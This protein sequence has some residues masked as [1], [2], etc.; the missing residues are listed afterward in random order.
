MSISKWSLFQL[1]F[2]LMA[3][4]GY[5]QQ[6]DQIRERQIEELTESMAAS[7]DAATETT[8]LLE[9]LNYYAS[10][11]ILINTATEEEL[12]RLNL[13]NF[14][15]VSTIL[16]YREKY[17]QILTL[18]ELMVTGDFREDLLQKIQP[19]VLF[20]QEPDSLEKRREQRIIQSLLVRMKETFPTSSGFTSSNGKTPVYEGKPFGT[21]VRYRAESGKWLEMGITAETDAGEGMFNRSNRLGFD[22]LSGFIGWNGK[23]VLRKVV[24]GDFHLRFG[25][26]LNLWSGG[27]V[28]YA[29]DLSSLMKTGEGIRPYSSTDENLFFRGIAIKLGFKPWQL[30]VFCSSKRC[31]T[32]LEPDSLGNNQITSFRTDGLHRTSSEIV[33][34]KNVNETVFGGFSDFRFNKWRFGILASFQKF[35]Y[36]VTKGDAPYKAKSFEGESNC[37]FGVDYHLILNQVSFFGEAGCSQNQK[38]A[39]LSGLVWKAHPQFSLSFLYRHYDAAF[40]SFYSGAFAEGSGVR[41]EEGLYAACE[42]FPMAKL[43]FSAQADLFYFPWMT[44]QTISPSHGHVIAFQLERSVKS[45][46][47][48]YVHARFV[49]KPQKFSASTGTPEQLD[50]STAKWR[51]HFDWKLNDL[52]Q[53]RSRLEYVGY[54]YQSQKEN[55]ILAFQDFI[56]TASHALKLWIRMVYY[57]TD[58]YNSRVYSFENDMLYYYSIPEFHGEGIRTY[59]NLKWQPVK[60]LTFYMKGGFTLRGGATSMGSGYDTSNG[61]HRFDVRGQIC[62]RF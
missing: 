5:A 62:L 6:P 8:L 48:I 15:Q 7:D 34:E 9:D 53:I 13:F 29:S 11:P 10:H 44:Y 26:G 30:S 27:G 25:Q 43:K 4:S 54:R 12:L 42:Y 19:F 33:D 55:G 47:I 52:I 24:L 57:H 38:M 31:D 49:C 35:G 39:F 51:I 22:F 36:P 18:K 21:L 60:S 17:G 59:L 56:C 2:M 40:Q 45:N 58:G 23:G 50:E 1:I 32:N 14:K 20:T 61:D 37:N 28:S 16:H 46:M 41:N 3:V